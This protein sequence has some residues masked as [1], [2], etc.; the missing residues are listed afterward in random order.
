M[1][2]DGKIDE[3]QLEHVMRELHLNPCSDQ[4]AEKGECL[5][6][7]CAILW[8]YYIQKK[9]GRNQT[10]K[11]CGN[12]LV[13]GKHYTENCAEARNIADH[14]FSER[15]TFSYRP[16]DIAFLYDLTKL[17]SADSSKFGTLHK[18][19]KKRG[20][21]VLKTNKKVHPSSIRGNN[22]MRY[23]LVNH[24]DLHEYFV[25]I[26]AMEV[27]AHEHQ[28][29]KR[30]SVGSNMYVLLEAMDGSL[31]SFQRHFQM[32]DPYYWNRLQRMLVHAL[33]GLHELN[34]LGFS[35][36]DVK[37]E[38]VLYKLDWEHNL[39]AVKWADF[40]CLATLG[41]KPACTT[42]RIDDPLQY[43]RHGRHDQAD[44]SQHDRFGF[45]IMVYE[46]L[47]SN[48]PAGPPNK[49]D[50]VWKG[51]YN[52]P[53]GDKAYKLHHNIRQLLQPNPLQPLSTVAY[54][55][56][57]NERLFPDERRWN[58]GEAFNYMKTNP[59]QKDT[60]PPLPQPGDLP[61]LP[62]PYLDW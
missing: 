13:D 58:Y 12:S 45:G 57:V 39:V 21:A 60:L 33:M 51:T 29:H 34:Q 62:R 41:E 42:E 49:V 8:R 18:I 7:N 50:K 3:D 44:F 40:D 1:Q 26:Y 52:S 25:E 47:F 23:L 22:T 59:I 43:P 38:N 37:K 28:P 32:R 17:E 10:W 46:L 5:Q 30:K 24:Q 54:H 53:E 20:D 56:I 11:R 15:D 48:H 2:D 27:G 14:M 4:D 55:F 19:S 9:H 35:H 16:G 61:P 31:A 6:R 36:N